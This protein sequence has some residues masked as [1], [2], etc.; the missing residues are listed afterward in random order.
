M[1]C[2]KSKDFL[3]T[4]VNTSGLFPPLALNFCLT[5]LFH[6]SLT[7][8]NVLCSLFFLSGQN[9]VHAPRLPLKSLTHGFLCLWNSSEAVERGRCVCTSQTEIQHSFRL[10]AT[11]CPA[12]LSLVTFLCGYQSLYLWCLLSASGLPTCLSASCFPSLFRSSIYPY[13]LGR[14]ISQ[15][16]EPHPFPEQKKLAEDSELLFFC[17]SFFFPLCK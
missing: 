13:L 10:L 6:L 3:K 14:S 1:P 11:W 15:K 5:Q 8:V 7:P 16:K 4:S 17:F 2:R 12:R 9:L